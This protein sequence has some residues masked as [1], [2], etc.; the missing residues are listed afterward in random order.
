MKRIRS[1]HS[2]LPAGL[3]V[4]L[5][6]LAG[7]LIERSITTAAFDRLEA[8]Q[9]AQDA[10]R[11]RVALDATLQVLHNYGSTNSIWDDSSDS[12]LTGNQKD[13]AAAFPP[14]E[15][16]RLYGLDGVL[17]V[18]R[19]GTLRTGGLTLGG[20][21]FTPPPAELTR[22]QDLKRLYAATAAPGEARCGVLP[23]SASPFLFCGLAAHN[24]NADRPPAGGLIYLKALDAAS[25][26]DLGT[27]V[28][29]PITLVSRVRPG[30]QRQ[31]GL[32]S[33][34]GEVAVST[35]ILSAGRVAVDAAVPTIDGGSI[36]LEAARPRPIHHM[37]DTIALATLLLMLG[38]GA[39]LLVLVI[40]LVGRGIR[41]Q[42][43]PLRVTADAVISSGDRTLRIGR[44]GD[45]D[46]AALG[47][48][49]DRMLD[50]LAAQGAE[51]EREHA[52]RQ[53]QMST[54]VAGQRE[55][56]KRALQRAQEVL[57]ETSELVVGPLAAVAAQAEA[58]RG[59]ADHIDDQV[60]Q[61]ERVAAGV[62]QRAR[63]A[64][65]VVAGLG[66]SLRQVDHIAQLING[67]TRQTNLLALNATIEAARAGAAGAG[68]SVVAT[69]VKTLATD[70]A[71]ST[72]EITSAVSS[73]QHAADAV[74][75]SIAAMTEGIGGIGDATTAIRQ[76][77]EQQRVTMA[78]LD[79]QVGEALAR[80]RA[81]AGH[82]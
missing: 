47:E 28:D 10:G 77:A 48:S 62:M 82:R 18:G 74:A 79:Q 11:V 71:A 5:V 37:A 3:T 46:I 52:A 41:Q 38:T 73:L 51:L 68:F 4:L 6:V 20:D 43:R 61:T 56:E 30:S 32:A 69:E 70:T 19:D 2:S 13:F 35:S 33:S 17:G 16:H 44:T 81:M 57:D 23:S 75:A 25:V 54:V 67:L 64:D 66:D 7:F 26:A 14:S 53:E 72:G 80:A 58:V 24:G 8:A 9:V 39:L 21:R 49:I 63:E 27:Q 12:V 60:E 65:A 34:V 40:R 59:D 29:L 22:P 42:V 76:V 36:I 55:A 45:G 78:Q 50:A 1:T 15:V 31:P